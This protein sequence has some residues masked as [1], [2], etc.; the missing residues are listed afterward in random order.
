QLPRQVRRAGR[1]LV[2]AGGR[3]PGRHCAGRHLAVGHGSGRM[4]R[5]QPDR[6]RPVIG[7]GVA[8]CIKRRRARNRQAGAQH[9]A[10]EVRIAAVMAAVFLAHADGV[11]SEAAGDSVAT[12]SRRASRPRPRC[13]RTGSA[14]EPLNA[15]RSPAMPAAPLKP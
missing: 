8:A 13:C 7:P 4:P 3:L 10:G 5:L 2:A 9:D 6:E 15:A 1:D 11:C 14:K 12:A